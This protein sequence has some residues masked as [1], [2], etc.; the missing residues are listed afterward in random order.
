MDIRIVAVYVITADILKG[1]NHAEDPQCQMSD[2][3]VITTAIVAALYFSGNMES[4]RWL[5]QEQGYI[6]QMLSKS[7]FNR[8]LHRVKHLVVTLLAVLGEVWKQ[9]NEESI[10]LIDTFPVAVCDNI[11]IR[12][13][14]LDQDE[15]YRG[16]QP[17]KR[18]YFYGLKV[19]ILVTQT[20]APVEFFLTPGSFSDTSGLDLF[21]CD[22]PQGS[23]IYGDKAY[24]WY[25]LEDLLA[26]VKIYLVPVRKKH[27]KRQL[28]PWERFLQA[29]M[30]Q[31]VETASSNVERLLPKHIHAVTP[32]GFELKVVLFLL[33]SSFHA[34]EL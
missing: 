2:A 33:A 25:L 16:Y 22:L 21:A 7:R 31:M 5:L 24:N 30:R 4:A 18:R 8:R 10:S 15:A 26:D 28:P 34:L 14:R 3:E 13:C 17:S 12:R 1:L 27:S 6:P 20:G 32:A 11:R 23:T 9:L 19:H 29:R